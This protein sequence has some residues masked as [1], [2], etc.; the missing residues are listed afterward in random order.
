MKCP[1]CESTNIHTSISSGYQGY[2]CDHCGR[3]SYKK[4]VVRFN[5]N[6]NDKIIMPK[7]LTAENGAKALMMGE[8]IIYREM[9]DS[10]ND[11]SYTMEI[12]VDWTTIKQIYKIAVDNLGVKL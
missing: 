8:F 12:P 6:D 9:F 10:E 2:M 3:W 5:N 11:E 1:N 7:E 4:D